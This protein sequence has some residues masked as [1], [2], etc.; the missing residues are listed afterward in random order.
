MGNLSP[1]VLISAGGVGKMSAALAALHDDHIR[2]AVWRQPPVHLTIS[3]SPRS[4]IFSLGSPM[5]SALGRKTSGTWLPC[6]CSYL[7]GSFHHLRSR[8]IRSRSAG[9]NAQEIFDVVDEFGQFDNICLCITSLIP[10]IP[11]ACES[12]EIPTLSKEAA[13]PTFYRVYK[14]SDGHSEVINNILNQLD[15]HPM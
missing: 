13:H 7:Q 12:I 1:F 11:P 6:S 5:S 8:R 15:F 2:G 4:R 9:T 14:N 10:K 3:F